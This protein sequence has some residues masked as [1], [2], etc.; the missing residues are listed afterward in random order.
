LPV[1]RQVAAPEIKIVSLKRRYWL[2]L[3][4]LGSALVLVAAFIATETW[5]DSAWGRQT[6]E[7]GLS[8]RFGIPVHLQG[9]YDTRLL[10]FVGASGNG[11]E[12]GDSGSG[13][14]LASSGRYRVALAIIP[15]FRKHLQIEGLEIEDFR[16]S[17]SIG[18]GASV[19]VKQLNYQAFAAS[20][21][22]PSTLDFPS[23]GWKFD[24]LPGGFEFSGIVLDLAGQTVVGQGCLL[25]TDR[26][27]QA[28]VERDAAV[29]L[30]LV[31]SAERFDLDAARSVLPLESQGENALPLTLNVKFSARELTAAGGVARNAL[32]ELGNEPD[33]S[34]LTLYNAG[35]DIE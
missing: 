7:R 35:S 27:P 4:L 26:A 16:M 28:G 23:L 11:L 34:G 10:P 17:L 2:L 9:D 8:E 21:E 18:E 31:L 33:C 12:F 29:A 5:L 25:S 13:D 15:L 1:S 30:N 32:I 22:K 24:Y 19:Q 20:G 6:L 14:F 3:I